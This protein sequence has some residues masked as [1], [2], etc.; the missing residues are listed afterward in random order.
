MDSIIGKIIDVLINNPLT[1][2]VILGVLCVIVAIIG[3]IPIVQGRVQISGRRAVALGVFGVL[4]IISSVGL[5]WLLASLTAAYPTTVVVVTATA[6]LAASQ[7][8]TVVQ[9]PASQQITPTRTDSSSSPTMPTPIV[10]S[11]ARQELIGLWEY[12]K[13]RAPM[14][15]PAGS[16]QAIVASGD[17]DNSGTCHVKV[18]RS[19]ELVQGLGDGTFQLWRVS[20]TAEQIEV[21]ITRIQNGAAAHAGGACPR[22]E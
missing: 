20:G 7:P 11:G 18:F 3:E 9:A 17:I 15:E 22:L 16:N 12:Q 8:A 2:L 1:V 13:A 4:L 5:S 6:P 19:G 14:P 21:T 10:I